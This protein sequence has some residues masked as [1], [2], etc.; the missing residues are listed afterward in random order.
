[1]ENFLQAYKGPIVYK[2][3]D[4]DVRRKAGMLVVNCTTDRQLGIS[5]SGR[6]RG[7]A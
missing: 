7:S 6:W 5:P 1:L 4:M 2:M 3:V